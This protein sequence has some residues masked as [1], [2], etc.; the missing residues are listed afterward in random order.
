M[1][2]VD[3]LHRIENYFD[4]N[5]NLF[6]RWGGLFAL[7][8]FTVFVPYQFHAKSLE[9]IKIQQQ[10]NYYLVNELQVANNRL[11]FLELSYEQKKKVMRDVECL[12]KN[13]YFEAEGESRTGKIA[14]AEVTMNRVKSVN[15]PTSVCGVVYQK[16]KG[17]CQFS[18]VCESGK[19]VRHNKSWDESVKIAE[20]I[21]ILKHKYGIIG[22]ATHF[23]A[24]YVE[25]NWAQTKEFVK[26][27]GNHLF[28]KG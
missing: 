12:A 25:P 27:I 19:K 24:D 22:N 17:V 8:F 4:R 28:Y 14:V 11:H 7:I 15:Y 1:N 2:A 26:Q 6:C 21:L 10:E 23:H 18:W 13:I 3:I 20:S 5:H 9:K 16:K